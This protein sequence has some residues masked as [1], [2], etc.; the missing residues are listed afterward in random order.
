[1]C[2]LL[3]LCC[4]SRRQQENQAPVVS[5]EQPF[6]GLTSVVYVADPKVTAQLLKG[7]H[8]VE[9]G[10]WRWTEKQFSVALKVPAAGKPV[11]LQLKFVLPEPLMARLNSVTLTATVNG[12]ALPPE[13]YSKA[14]DQVYTR[15][16]PAAALPDEV[17][18]VDFRLD[19]ALPPDAADRRELGVVVSSVGLE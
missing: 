5:E 18:R 2:S 15:S 14:G 9:Q 16:V 11:T 12:V 7:W 6:P 1:M 8:P 4:C 17:V 13:T 10:S 3:L 19:K